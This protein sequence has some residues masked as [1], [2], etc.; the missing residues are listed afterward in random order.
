LKKEYLKYIR[1]IKG[2][3]YPI[4]DTSLSGSF[5]KKNLAFEPEYRR[6]IAIE[7][8]DDIRRVTK[9]KKNLCLG[10]LQKDLQL[11]FNGRFYIAIPLFANNHYFGILRFIFAG[12]DR[13]YR[14]AGN[15]LRIRE[16]SLKVF[17]FITRI[18]SLHLENY[19]I[20]S[21][22]NKTYFSSKKHAEQ[23]DSL[24][25]FL[26]TQCNQLA[27]II[28]SRG[29]VAHLL[30]KESNRITI[31]GSSSVLDNN[32][33][34]V[35][36]KCVEYTRTFIGGLQANPGILAAHINSYKNSLQVTTYAGSPKGKSLNI[37]ATKLKIP[38]NQ[39]SSALRTLKSGRYNIAVLPIPNIENGFVTFLNHRH[40]RFHGKDIEMIYPAVKNLGLELESYYYTEGI[41]NRTKAIDNMHDECARV[42][43]DGQTKGNQYVKQFIRI[44]GDMINGLDLFPFHIV[45]EYIS[46]EVPQMHKVKDKF[47]FR[48]I[49][50]DAYDRAP[51]KSEKWKKNSIYRLYGEQ[52]NS[53]WDY[54]A[55]F[56]DR[57][58]LKKIFDLHLHSEF[59]Y[60]DLPFYNYHST[61]RDKPGIV[62]AFTLIYKKSDKKWV[63]SKE[64]IKFSRFLSR[65][66]SLAWENFE[67]RIATKI[68]QQIDARIREKRKK[69]ITSRE[70][71]LIEI[72][73]LLA[74]GFNIDLCCFVLHNEKENSLE[75]TAANIHIPEKLSYNL[76]TDTNMLTV[77]S[78]LEE[79]NFRIFGRE[80]IEAIADGTKLKIIEQAVKN[81][82]KKTFRERFKGWGKKFD[83]DEIC[84]EHWM[85]QVIS[86]G[87]KP[88]GL[89]KLFLFKG[90]RKRDDIKRHKYVRHP[91]SDFEITLLERIQKHIFNILITHKNIQQRIEDMRNV[92]HQVVAPLSALAI[93]C[94]NLEKGIVA[95]EKINDKYLYIKI[96][97]RL[98]AKY[99]RNFQKILD[100]DTGNITLKQTEIPS[101]RKYVI[102]K[103]IDFQPLA[104]EKGISIKVIGEGRD[105]I[106]LKVD[107]DLFEHVLINLF[108]NAVKYSFD[109]KERM[110]FG[111]ENITESGNIIANVREKDDQVIITINNWGIEIPEDE[112]E[113]IFKREYRGKDAIEY[114][115]IGTGIGLFIAREIVELHGGSLEL[116]PSTSKH[117]TI[118]KII[119][120]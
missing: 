78:F 48:N 93:Q 4:D 3:S 11:S 103:A 54:S 97:S 71:E 28:E 60:F 41:E 94:S 7:D 66:V 102:D 38:G 81:H 17:E 58:N 69:G 79:R 10:R 33:M 70:L 98:A 114:S 57:S 91:F 44:L 47:F 55:Y 27:E 46:D 59:S 88:L 63:E 53:L 52:K 110:K 25:E 116:L 83:Y 107:I 20:L 89:I 8:L 61:N 65:Q 90:I 105:D 74:D 36:G 104:K 96:Q 87:D 117:N 49:T 106:P 51:F 19:Y 56:E 76:E 34:T 120:P 29:A 26:N 42:M 5:Y 31:S 92:L 67:D 95:P 85:S 99:A 24:E 21:G 113:K 43:T 108:D 22:Y 1:T 14:D 15:R 84:M 64:F 118:F 109:E 77:K 111:L 2:E 40:R 101:L 39:A 112:R 18:I 32:C 37:N 30:D 75:L 62:G 45:W 50:S 68:E 115:P 100:I 73:E 72:A 6:D 23:F 13:F 86:I 35:S 12:M 16:E 80:K 82:M 119:F 9:E